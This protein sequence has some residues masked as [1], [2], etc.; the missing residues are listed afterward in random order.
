VWAKTF[1]TAGV[2]SQAG[3]K[4]CITAD[5]DVTPIYYLSVYAAMAVR[6]GLDELE[7]L[8]SVTLN[9]AEVLGIDDRKGQLKAGLDADIVLWDKHPFAYD[10][11]VTGV[12]LR[13]KAFS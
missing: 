11:H 1:D 2:L 8:K 4:V 6:H 13:G 12:F 9:P 10:A 7:G 5:H 3:L